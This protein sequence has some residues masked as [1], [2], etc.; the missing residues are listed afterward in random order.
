MKTFMRTEYTTLECGKCK[1]KFS[2][3]VLGQDL[4]KGQQTCQYCMNPEFFIDEPEQEC[5]S[6][7]CLS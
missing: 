6:S 7:V 1:Q 2:M 5:S 3:L 4:S